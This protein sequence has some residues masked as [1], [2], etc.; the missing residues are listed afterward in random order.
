VTGAV[1]LVRNA[2]RCAIN[3]FVKRADGIGP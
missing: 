3:V 2:A 1:N